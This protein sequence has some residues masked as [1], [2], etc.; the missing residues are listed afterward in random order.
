VL[1]GGG[2]KPPMPEPMMTPISSRFSFVEVEAGI[3]QRLVPGINAEL[4]VAVRAPDFLGR[5]KRRRG[6]KIFHLA[7]DLRVERRE[8]SKA[9]MRSMPHWPEQ[10]CSRKRP[11]DVRAASPRQ[12]R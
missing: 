1:L 8:A 6:I 2:G 5:G 4:R 10:G 3:E 12:G 7:G 11:V 9:V